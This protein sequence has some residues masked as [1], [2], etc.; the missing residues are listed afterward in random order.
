MVG[1][2]VRDEVGVRAQR[3]R[4]LAEE[5]HVGDFAGPEALLVQERHDAWGKQTGHTLGQGSYHRTDVTS[6]VNGSRVTELT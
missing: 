6:R 2:L 4:H 1:A 5:R 3:L